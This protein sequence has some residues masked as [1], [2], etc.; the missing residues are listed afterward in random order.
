MMLSQMGFPGDSSGKEPACQPRRYGRCGFDPC[1]RKIPLEE[2]RATYSTILAW[3]IP[4]TEGPGGLQSI[5][6]QKVGHN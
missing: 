6:L 1:V 2:G 5:G 4:W 3:R